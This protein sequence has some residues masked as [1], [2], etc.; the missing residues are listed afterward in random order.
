M[1]RSGPVFGEPRVGDDWVVTPFWLTGE[2]PRALRVFVSPPHD[3]VREIDVSTTLWRWDGL[4]SGSLV[5][6]RIDSLYDDPEEVVTSTLQVWTLQNG[7]GPIGPVHGLRATAS[8]DEV[9]LAWDSLDSRAARL[10]IQR[11]DGVGVLASA[12][13]NWASGETHHADVQPLQEYHYTVRSVANSGEA[14]AATVTV[15]VPSQRAEPALAKWQAAPVNLAFGSAAQP[16]VTTRVAGV[17]DL[18]YFDGQ[19]KVLHRYEISELGTTN[20]T[21]PVQTLNAP[22]ATVSA[23]ALGP[24]HLDLVWGFEDGRHAWWDGHEWRE[25]VPFDIPPGAASVGCLQSNRVDYFYPAGGTVHHTWWREGDGWQPDQS[26]GGSIGGTRIAATAFGPERIDLFYSSP[27]DALIHR[28]Y[29]PSR[30]SW[31]EEQT[32]GQL[33]AP[34]GGLAAACA[35][36]DLYVFYVRPDGKVA[37]RSRRPDDTWNEER[38]DVP[39]IDME[40]AALAAT[41]WQP[42]H[43]DLIFANARGIMWRTW[44]SA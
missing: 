36:P 23:T 38:A 41:A 31:S 12:V 8:S 10:E 20:E 35:A 22:K 26:V 6:L 40:V 29:D 43:F 42:F 39:G 21:L 19:D 7:N 17:M 5:N 11:D 15:R 4:P 30:E 27:S 18:F 33:R 13:T 16:A 24:L 25:E 14:A 1:T 2:P 9:V 28:Q 44:L 3:V 32:L 34:I 37:Y